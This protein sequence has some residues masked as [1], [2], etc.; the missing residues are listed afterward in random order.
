M[1]KSIFFFTL[2]LFPF[3][4]YSQSKKEE[5]NVNI[6]GSIDLHYD[7]YSYSEEN[8]STFRPRYPESLF[9]FNANLNIQLGKHFSIPIGLNITN[10]QTLYNLPT[11]PDENIID[12]VS[13]PRNNIS[14]HPEYKW[15]KTHIGTHSPNY[16]DLSTG[17]INIFGGGI[18]LNPGKFIFSANY[19]ISQRAIE[20]NSLFNIV[21][22][23]EQRIIAARIGIGKIEG[24]KFTINIVKIKDDINSL[25]NTPIDTKPIEGIT[26]A[27]LIQLKLGENIF[28]K[29]ETAASVYT[30]DLLNSF[31]L[32]SDVVDSVKDII[33]INA[34]SKGDFSHISSLEWKSKKL[35]IG[36]EVKYIGPGFVPAG[37]RNIEKD[38]L[39][40]KFKTGLKLFKGKTSINGM[41]GVRTNNLKNTT[42]QSTKR[43]ISNV[44]LFSQITKSLSLNTSYSNFGFNN[45]VSED[46]LRIEMVNNT[47]SISP[48]YL[49]IT[50]KH[51]HQISANGNFNSFDQFDSTA[52]SFVASKSKSYSLNYNLMFK[53]IPLNINIMFLN[54]NNATPVSDFKMTNY[55]STIS[56]K[57]LD[58]KITPSLSVNLASITKEGFTKD[59]R[60]ST[61]FKFD[62]KINKKLKFRFSYRFNKYTYGS[63]KINA[64]TQENRFKYSLQKKF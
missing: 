31:Y 47:F 59:K 18:D 44:S 1:K 28:L 41:F 8:F 39:D 27:P 4:I 43:I 16:S 34:S 38:I 20:S 14:I 53:E 3:I 50:E 19:G 56:Y 15:I 2:T 29:T 10:Q 26:I 55:T 22:A 46:I 11:I 64:L 24:S 9:R 21:G 62:Y 32:D 48:S 63:S 42:L 33:T 58:K 23:Y 25:I 60:A 36:G 12:Y 40:F 30:S 54:L 13:N 5:S 6:N 49:F 51:N 57:L 52:A 17:D 37:F 35:T 7:V 45:N 61:R